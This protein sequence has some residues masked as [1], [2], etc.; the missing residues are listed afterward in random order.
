MQDGFRPSTP[1]V[2][3]PA[4]RKVHMI[5]EKI[6]MPPLEEENTEEIPAEEATEAP[7]PESE[8]PPADNQQES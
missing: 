7:A 5:S 2:I 8:I 3:E 4:A 6:E 1:D